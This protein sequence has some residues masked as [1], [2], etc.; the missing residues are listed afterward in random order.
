MK[1]GF[2]RPP[3]SQEQKR[4]LHLPTGFELR[5]TGEKSGAW[6]L[7]E[8]FA[9][10]CM[11]TIMAVVLGW[12]AFQPIAPQ[13]FDFRLSQGR[14][15]ARDCLVEIDPESQ[16]LVASSAGPLR[17]EQWCTPMQKWHQYRELEAGRTVFAFAGKVMH[18]HADRRRVAFLRVS[19][20]SPC[21]QELLLQATRGRGAEC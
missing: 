20:T 13:A 15:K 8:I 16:E 21:G 14:S 1:E 2:Q 6:R 7:L 10:L 17:P 19:V 4:E 12:N 9:G 3:Q 18:W 11:L 5:R